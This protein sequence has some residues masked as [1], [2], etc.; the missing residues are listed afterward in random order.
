MRVRDICFKITEFIDLAWINLIAAVRR[1]ESSKVFTNFSSTLSSFNHFKALNKLKQCS[2]Y[3][4]VT[5]LM[6]CCQRMPAYLLARHPCSLPPN[7]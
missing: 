5:N 1:E 3:A 4:M 7:L 6:Q 2:A